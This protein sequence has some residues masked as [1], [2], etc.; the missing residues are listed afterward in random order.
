MNTSET[1][2]VNQAQLYELKK[3]IN[4]VKNSLTLCQLSLSLMEKDKE[5]SKLFWKNL[6]I[7][8][9]VTVFIG[10]FAFLSTVGILALI[11]PET[12]SLVL[13][14]VEVLEKTES[15]KTGYGIKN[16]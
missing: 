8:I 6:G 3:E 9:V 16:T 5:K 1:H 11:N 13:P 7:G 15:P 2:W 12:R 14:K 10:I 4:E